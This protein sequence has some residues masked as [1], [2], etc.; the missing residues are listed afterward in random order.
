MSEWLP[1]WR[2]IN[3]R[4]QLPMCANRDLLILCQLPAEEV[5]EVKY[6]YLVVN[7]ELSELPSA[8]SA[9]EV[10]P[11]ILN[12]HGA[13]GWQLDRFWDSDNGERRFF[14]LRKDTPRVVSQESRV[15]SL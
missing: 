2:A 15:L 8:T 13:R 4:F 6:Q 12:A 3:L 7:Q 9:S 10:M 5:V 14:L 11:N 1:L